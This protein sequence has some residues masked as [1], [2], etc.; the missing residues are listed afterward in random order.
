MTKKTNSLSTIA[1]F[2]FLLACILS[3]SGA[4]AQTRDLGLIKGHVTDAQGK[5]VA[6]ADVKLENK[7]PTFSAQLRLARMVTTLSMAF[8]S[9]AN[10]RSL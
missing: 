6:G 5:A 3:P 7:R 1:F 8:R 4:N 2:A 10:T 9:P